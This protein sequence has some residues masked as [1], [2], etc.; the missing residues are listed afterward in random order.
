MSLALQKHPLKRRKSLSPLHVKI[1]NVLQKKKKNLCNSTQAFD[2]I[3]IQIV[4][5]VE[6]Q[7]EEYEHS[8][9]VMKI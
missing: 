8:F 2:R 3:T 9:F 5:T 1:T 4:R 7:L 6:P